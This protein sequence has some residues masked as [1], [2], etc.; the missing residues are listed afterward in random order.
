MV[1]IA[2]GRLLAAAGI[3]GAGLIAGWLI[4]QPRVDAA[5][6][7]T[8]LAKAECGRDK[9]AITV[10]HLEQL[11]AGERAAREAL[12]KAQERAKEA[13]DEYHREVDRISAAVDGLPRRVSR[14]C[15]PPGEA[16]ASAAGGGAGAEAGDPSPARGRILRPGDG[17]AVGPDFDARPWREYA[18]QCEAVAAGL[19][20]CL[21]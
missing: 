19:R 2:Y 1:T 15:Q 20:A 5:K 18:R 16:S 13:T 4:Q 12:T 7:V 3:F 14:L 10:Q 17:A 8:E 9:A 11:V 21:R 6:A